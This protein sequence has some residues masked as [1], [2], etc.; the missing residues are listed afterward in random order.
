MLPSVLEYEEEVN[1]INFTQKKKE[2]N[3]QRIKQR[4]KEMY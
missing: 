3:P 1:N 2:L 4:L